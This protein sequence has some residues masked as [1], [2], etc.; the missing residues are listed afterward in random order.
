MKNLSVFLRMIVGAIAILGFSVFWIVMAL[1]VALQRDEK[2][3]KED[4]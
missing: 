2:E 4:A 1:I 3:N